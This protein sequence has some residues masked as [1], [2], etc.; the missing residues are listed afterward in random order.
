MTI[1]KFV[2]PPPKSAPTK[3]SCRRKAAESRRETKPAARA[4]LHNAIALALAGVGLIFGSII[5]PTT[6]HADTTEVMSGTG[7]PVYSAADLAQINT[8]YVQPNWP[9][10]DPVGLSTPEQMWPLSGLGSLTLEQSVDQGVTDLN[11]VIAPQLDS[12]TPVEVFGVSQSAIIASL[13][14]EN[15]DP[16]GTPSNLPAYFV[17]VGDPMNP[18]GGIEARFPNLDIKPL[19][20]DFHGA[21][22]AN[23][24]PTTIYTGEYDGFADFCQYPIDIP[25][26]VNALLGI[27]FVHLGPTYTDPT[28]LIQLPTDGGLTT[29]YMIPTENLPLLDPLRELGGP[30]GNAVADLLQPD[31]TAI[32]NFG[33]GNPDYGWSLGPA[34]IPTPAELLPPL[35]DIQMLINQLPMDTMAGIT[36]LSADLPGISLDITNLLVSLIP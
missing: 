25:C 36:A 14:M 35:T 12:G 18:N 4:A 29:Y 13:E 32:V 8:L 11:H 19:G 10:T 1:A 20:I 24:F 7:T 33:Y 15:L 31:L 3:V 26:D 9:G 21:T 22:P 5:Y 2:C 6:A 28:N 34:N 27:L 17:L 16:S 30:V 23:D